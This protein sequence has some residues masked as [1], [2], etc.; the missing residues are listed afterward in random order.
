MKHVRTLLNI[1]LLLLGLSPLIVFSSSLFPFTFPKTIYMQILIEIMAAGAALIWAREGVK[2]NVKNS[3]V[4]AF[5]IFIVVGFVAAIFGVNLHQSLWSDM[6]RAL[7]WIFWFHLAIFLILITSSLIDRVWWR[8]FIYVTTGSSML[9]ALIGVIQ[10]RADFLPSSLQFTAEEFGTRV[11]STAGNPIYLAAALVV[12]ILAAPIFWRHANKIWQKIILSVGV[13]IS[14]VALYFTNTRGSFLGL[15]AGLAV[16]GIV[17]GFM[18][19][20]GIIRRSIIA[21]VLLGIFFSGG[22]LLARNTALVQKTPLGKI[23][24]SVTT[25]TITL[26]TRLINWKT[27]LQGFAARPLLGWGPENYRFV[28]DQFYDPALAR[29]SFY[30]TRADKPHNMWLELLATTGLLGFLSYAAIYVAIITAVIKMKRAGQMGK[31]E[32]AAILATLSGY[33]VQNFFAFETHVPLFLFIVLLAWIVRISGAVAVSALGTA[34]QPPTPPR[35]WRTLVAG[36]VSVAVIFSILMVN[37]APIRASIFTSRGLNAADQSWEEASALFR[38]GLDIKT[39]YHFESW[40]WFADSLVDHGKAAARKEYLFT[41]TGQA[42]F[43]ED[44]QILLDESSRLQKK[45]DND[46]LLLAF[47]G[48]VF[49]HLGNLRHDATALGRAEEAFARVVVMTPHRQESYVLLGQVFLAEKKYPEAIATYKKAVDLDPSINAARWYLA[50]ATY[51]SGDTKG[52]IPLITD[53]FDRGYYSHESAS[54]RDVVSAVFM[55]AK[56]YTRLVALYE[57]LVAE[58]DA[59]AATWAKLA[60]AYKEAGRYNEARNAAV[61]AAQLDPAFQKETDEFIK[62]LPRSL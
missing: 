40:R 24:N 32:N 37:I 26:G 33:A 18:S 10:R 53:A 43:V 57:I 5:L 38:Q 1:C 36:I 14:L 8:R 7:G 46:P 52:A 45:Y 12:M 19:A 58:K 54:L 11:S 55:A 50:V 61:K 2:W 28:N 59:T 4:A 16:F 27:A 25:R 15:A 60:V 21:V 13:V 3:V 56:D 35:N 51:V 17:L 42:R 9:M 20:K 44:V 29:F 62:T 41:P 22:I 39:P 30:E 23:I 6:A 31:I 49:Y 47:V 34:G 48:R